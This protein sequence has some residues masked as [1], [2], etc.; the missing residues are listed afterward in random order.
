MNDTL[1]LVVTYNRKTL[2]KECLDALFSQDAKADI[3]IVDNASNDGTDSLVKSYIDKS[4]DIKVYY[5]NT[6]ANLGG[7]GGYNAGLREAC[8]YDYKYFWLMDDDTIAHSDSLKELKNNANKLKDNFSFLSSKV[9]WIDG[10]ICKTNVQRKAVAKK[11]KNFES[12]VVNVDYASFVSLFIKKSD[13]LKVGLPIKD[14]F[15]WTDDLEYTRRLSLLCGKGYLIN[16]SVVTHKCKENIGVDISKDSKDRL[17]RYKYIYRNDV[18]TFKREGIRGHIFLYVRYIYHLLK[19]FF[20]SKDSKLEKIKIMTNGYK[21]GFSF[22]PTI[23]YI[24]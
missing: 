18:F 6:G 22:N 16:S 21:E 19:I 4:N 13:V 1:A 9:I 2:L 3:L 5:Y 12:P 10:S 24:K 11:I 20:T 15:I 7:A 8:E 17:D 14:F 23:E